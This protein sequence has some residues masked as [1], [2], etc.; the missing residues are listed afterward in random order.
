[1]AQLHGR[2]G[3]HEVLAAG[4]DRPR[5]RAGPPRRLAVAI[6]RLRPGRRGP[7]PAFQSDA[8]RHAADGRRPA[9]HGHQPGAGGRHRPGHGRDGV[10][11]PR[12]RGRRRPAARGPHPRRRLL[13]RP[14]TRR[15]ADLHRERRAPRRPRRPDRRSAARVRAGR[16]D[17]PDAGRAPPGRISLDGG[18]AGVPRHHHR[19]HLHQRPLRAAGA[20]ARLHPGFRRRHRATEVALQSGAPAGRVPGTRRGRT[21]PGST[22]GPATSG[23]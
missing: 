12:A 14:G 8:A 23:R 9:V 7:R 16:Q 4:S 21:G 13:G 19:R 20:G 18:P 2:V 3:W 15:R 6:G 11:L 17:R 1:M 5:Q 10:D 22:P